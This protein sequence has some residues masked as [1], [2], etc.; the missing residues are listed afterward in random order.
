MD[1]TLLRKLRGKYRLVQTTAND[2]IW[3][4]RLCIRALKWEYCY[5]DEATVGSHEYGYYHRTRDEAIR[6][7]IKFIHDKYRETGYKRK[8]IYVL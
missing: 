7:F 1:T 4:K 2:Y 3:E 5:W 8:K 6:A